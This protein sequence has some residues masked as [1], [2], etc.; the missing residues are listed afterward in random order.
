MN[1]SSR[2]PEGMPNRCIICGKPVH[3]SPSKPTGEAPCPRCGVLLWFVETS[4]GIWFF[5]KRE[6]ILG[7]SET[8][9][10]DVAASPARNSGPVFDLG[11]PVRINEGGFESFS[12]TVVAIDEDTKRVIVEVEIFGRATPVELESWQLS[13]E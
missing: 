7:R 11:D 13:R 1:I 12:G 2:T 9:P 6:S 10:D 5:N 8:P 4:D 3:L